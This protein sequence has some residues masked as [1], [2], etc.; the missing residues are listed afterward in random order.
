MQLVKE[1]GRGFSGEWWNM[2]GILWQLPLFE[3]CRFHLRYH[4]YGY[5]KVIFMR[6]LEL[7]QT[8]NKSCELTELFRGQSQEPCHKSGKDHDPQLWTGPCTL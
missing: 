1:G 3:L 2:E 5:L 6:N 7:F 4:D 8:K